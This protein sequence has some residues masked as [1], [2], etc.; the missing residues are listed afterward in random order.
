MTERRFR[1]P[2]RVDEDTGTRYRNG[3]LEIRLP[4]TQGVTARDKPIEIED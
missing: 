2:E 4:V 3:I 1:F